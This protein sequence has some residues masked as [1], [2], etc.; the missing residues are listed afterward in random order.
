MRTRTPATRPRRVSCSLRL[1]AL[2]RSSACARARSVR[3]RRASRLAWAAA[4]S[5]A[6]L[7]EVFFC[8]IEA[9]FVCGGG[10]GVEVV[11]L[12]EVVVGGAEQEGLEGEP[13]PGP[14]DQPQAERQQSDVA[15]DLS[16]VLRGRVG[17]LAAA[18]EAAAVDRQAACPGA[19]D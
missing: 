12:G 16:G 13:R 3:A 15:G 4:F 6:V 2:R 1:A 14:D 8:A 17:D 18:A 5:S 9:S 11:V 19:G 10:V 7:C